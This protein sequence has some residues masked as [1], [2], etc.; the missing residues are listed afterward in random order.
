MKLVGEKYSG[1]LHCGNG[2][3]LLSTALEVE[4]NRIKNTNL[5]SRVTE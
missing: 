1:K 5:G 3:K 4:V 2:F